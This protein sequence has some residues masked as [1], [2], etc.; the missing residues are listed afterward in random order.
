MSS[1]N[2]TLA[3]NFYDT[4]FLTSIENKQN[5]YPNYS[6]SIGNKNNAAHKMLSRTWSIISKIA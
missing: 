5:I 3:T 6:L 1:G 4:I 2:V